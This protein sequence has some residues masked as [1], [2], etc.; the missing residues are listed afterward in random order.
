MKKI[1][2]LLCVLAFI[3][4]P[5]VA[6]GAGSSFTVIEDEIKLSDQYP[7]EEIREITLKAV[8]D[9]GDGSIPA[10][11]LNDITSGINNRFPLK[12]WAIYSVFI[13]GDHAGV[14]DGADDA[15][16]LTDTD[17]GLETIAGIGAFVG[18]TV[19]NTTDGSSC[20]ITANTE[21][22]VSCTLTGGTQNDWDVGDAYTIAAEPQE[23]SEIYIFQNGMDILQTGTDMVDNTTERTIFCK[24]D[25]STIATPVIVDD[26]IVII[27]QQAAAVNDAIVFVKLILI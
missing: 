22:T 27:T 11:T 13:D 12:G 18:Y 2:N 4:M 20:T 17:A 19:T 10:R 21:S 23:N 1:V 25:G 8:A 14:H 26:L 15:S 9:D 6:F 5:V 3:I 24:P 16:V 7:G